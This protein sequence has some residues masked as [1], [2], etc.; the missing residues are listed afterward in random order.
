LADNYIVVESAKFAETIA[1]LPEQFDIVI[2]A[3]NLEHCDER[4]D[5]LVAITKILKSGGHIY[6][7]LPTEKSIEFPGPRSGV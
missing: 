2:S 7:S 4:E 1:N 6:L 5:T 3:H